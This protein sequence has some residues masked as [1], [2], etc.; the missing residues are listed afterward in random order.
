[1]SK[2]AH[3]TVNT[4]V[5][6]APHNAPE[7]TRSFEMRGRLLSLGRGA[8]RVFTDQAETIVSSHG[9][10]LMTLIGGTSTRH[11]QVGPQSA[12]PQPPAALCEIGQV[13]LRRVK[14]RVLAGS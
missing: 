7:R 2:S 3:C 14:P 11:D 9:M 5:N 12:M 6:V 8:S 13:A 10:S 4:N 1:M